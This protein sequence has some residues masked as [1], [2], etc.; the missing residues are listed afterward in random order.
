MPQR[1]LFLTGHLAAG[2]LRKVL[3]EMGEVDFAWETSDIGVQVA[4]LMTAELIRRRLPREAIAADRIV[5]PGHCA[6]D[7]AAL[8]DELGLPIE[9]GPEDLH[10]L[11]AH[12]GQQ[13]LGVDL[14][15]HN[16]R[17]FAE[18]VEAPLLAIDEILARARDF[19][20]E[21]AD[22]IDLGCLPAT[23]FAH[24]DDAVAALHAAGFLVS[25]DSADPAELRRAGR[26]GAD[27]VLSLDETMLDL[28]SE[29]SA[30]PVLIP[31]KSGD[32]ES[33]CRAA[34]VLE[35]AGRPFILDSIL[36]PIPFGLAASLAR[37][38]ELRRR[39]PASRILM[40]IGN[41]TELVEA[42][43]SGINAVLFG[44]IAELGITDVL[45]VRKSPHCRSAIR[46]ADRARRIMHAAKALDRLPVGIDPGLA[47][48]RD[49]QP[50][51]A[52]PE[53]IAETAGAVRDANFRIEV[54]ADGIHLY[55][56]DG[57]HVA[58]DAFALY[59]RLGVEADGAHAF[60]LGAEL[61]KAQIAFELGK[62]YVQDDDL[63]WGVAVERAML[64]RLTHRAAGTTLRH[65]QASA[66][67]TSATSRR[68]RD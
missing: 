45:A 25:V 63:A 50:F 46:E 48:L 68:R 32:L 11:P 19:A 4:A 31:A 24:L 13:G 59:P 30:V 39:L 16:V 44:A 27:F 53:E 3:A 65:G 22:V 47:C 35:R 9:R 54:A 55:N 40:G 8:S 5:V 20:S 28:A 60:Y 23:P 37:Y 58:R 61:M 34:D 49:R 66:A 26:A 14:S 64:D 67:Q 12:F 52:T 36:D 29:M 43:T 41:L 56:R 62:R 33:L 15:R 18:I 10:D 2:R 57:H 21:G 17:I 51:G 6:G 38:G 42:D 7:L 1:I